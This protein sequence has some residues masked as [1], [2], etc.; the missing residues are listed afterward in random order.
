MKQQ[1]HAV[2]RT[3]AQFAIPGMQR[4]L[5]GEPYVQMNARWPGIPQA[6]GRCDRLV[7]K[8][9]ACE[10]GPACSICQPLAGLSD[11]RACTCTVPRPHLQNTE[12]R[13]CI[14]GELETRATGVQCSSTGHGHDSAAEGTS[15]AKGT[16]KKRVN[17]VSRNYYI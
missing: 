12:R 14:A 10:A 2:L 5:Q 4:N 15:L 1:R 3:P 17:V 8:T 7:S 9:G 6:A 16:P 11:G 13:C